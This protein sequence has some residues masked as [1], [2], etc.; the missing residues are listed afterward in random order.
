MI[1][2]LVGFLAGAVVVL[3]GLFCYVRFGFVDP[4][5]DAEPGS[6][7][8]KLAM[9]A[10][11]AS[12]DRRAPSLKNP[13]QPNE[14]NLLGGMKIYQANCAGCHGDISHPHLAFGDSFYPR[15]P[16]FVE[17]APDM[18]ENQNFYIVQHGVRLTGMPGWKTSLKESEVWQ[19]TTFLSHI[20]KLP[21]QVLAAWKAA[22]SEPETAGSADAGAK[23]ATKD[24]QVDTSRH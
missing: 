5:A 4:R 1:R 17:D 2:F 19:V 24:R 13:I 16:Q 6:L 8:T 7:E 15:V 14:E 18:P 23:T 12:V 10:L 20:D 22:A 3:L 9:P 21:P 11:D